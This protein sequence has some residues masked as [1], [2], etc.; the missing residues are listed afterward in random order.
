MKEDFLTS[1]SYSL[2]AF[3][4][5]KVVE[6]SKVFSKFMQNFNINLQVI[7]AKVL[8][9]TNLII[10]GRFSHAHDLLIEALNYTQ[11]K[12]DTNFGYKW[13]E[14]RR[15]DKLRFKKI[16]LS[17]I[18]QIKF[19]LINLLQIAFI[20]EKNHNFDRIRETFQLADW[21]AKKFIPRLDEIA[22]LISMYDNETEK[23]V[24]FLFYSVRWCDTGLQRN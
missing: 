15:K 13:N 22:K 9:A 2:V 17:Y 21:L 16:V 23:A 18:N 3:Q 14:M 6:G 1:T 11:N 8:F 20:N 7:K 10:A 5:A 24:S 12:I 4:I 19:I